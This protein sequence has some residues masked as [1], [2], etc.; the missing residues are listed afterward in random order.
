MRFARS[1]RSTEPVR[2]RR[3]DAIMTKHTLWPPFSNLRLKL[4][5]S[6]SPSEAC[7]GAVRRAE[8][9]SP[10]ARHISQDTGDFTCNHFAF[11][12]LGNLRSAHLLGARVIDSEGNFIGNRHRLAAGGP[13]RGHVIHTQGETFMPWW[14]K[15]FLETEYKMDMFP[16][17][18]VA[19]VFL[20]IVPS[21]GIIWAPVGSLPEDCPAHSWSVQGK[22]RFSIVSAPAWGYR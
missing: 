1:R 12:H 22:V 7:A 13:A 21:L 2:L 4:V 9:E 6:A 15:E 14:E 20:I 3:Q 17:G 19:A 5:P 16:K 11:N 18:I 8:S 10:V